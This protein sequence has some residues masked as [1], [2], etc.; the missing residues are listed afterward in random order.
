V[1][2]SCFI[3][4]LVVGCRLPAISQTVIIKGKADTNYLSFANTIYAYTYDD[5]ISFREKELAKS[6]LDE[7]GNFNLSF[8]ASAPIYVFLTIDNAKAEMICEPNKTYD[9]AFLAK[10]SNSANTL[11]IAVPVELEFNNSSETELNYLMADFTSRFETFLE[12][13]RGMIA[14]KES[15]IFEKIDTMKTLS[16]KKYYVYNNAYLN[17]YIEYSFASLIER[18]ALKGDRKIYKS[19]IDNKPVQYGN[20]DYMTFFNQYYSFVSNSFM[21]NPK[22]ETEVERQIFSS[23]MDYFSQNDFLENDTV[24]EMVILKSF[25]E[26]SRYPTK[27]KI[28]SMLVILE[29][30][31]K[32]CR[33]E[34]N[35]KSAENLRKKLSVMAVGKPVSQMSLQNMDGNPVLLSIFKGRYVY[36]TFWT[37]WSSSSTQELT[38]IPELKKLYGSKISFVSI[39]VDK[40]AETM[41]NFLKKNS[42][43]DW[44]FLYCDNYKKAKEE[45]NVLTVPAYFLIDPKGNVFKSPAPAPADIV[46][47]F[48]KIKKKQL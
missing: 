35:R 13:H 48:T 17:N 10:D 2:I 42:K 44:T 8:P 18:I 46:P 20:Y 26:H 21:N 14:K 24:C 9:I 43:L 41:K 38:L 15:A 11:S 39:C 1:I 7:K 27:Y 4:L 37:S 31:G 34:A 33:S 29:Q 45:F 32:E 16:I 12:D 6:K 22:T 25:A 28:N 30:A 23:L 36:L 3:F 47:L 5:F 40:K 19:F